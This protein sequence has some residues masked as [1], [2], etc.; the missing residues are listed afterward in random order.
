METLTL[1]TTKKVNGKKPEGPTG[2]V[3]YNYS[4]TE[5]KINVSYAASQRGKYRSIAQC[6]KKT[7][8]RWHRKD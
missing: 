2:K 7:H 6:G 4:G 3:R 8:N 5:T 1:P